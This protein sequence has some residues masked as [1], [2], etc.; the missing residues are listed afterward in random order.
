MG[1][2]SSMEARDEFPIPY[3]VQDLFLEKFSGRL[4]N[5]LDTPH[6]KINLF[7]NSLGTYEKQ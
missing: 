1:L 6:L 5:S 3:L 4:L 2:Q 7:P